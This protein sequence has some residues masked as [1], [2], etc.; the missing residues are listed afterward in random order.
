MFNDHILSIIMFTPA[1]GALVLLFM[2]KE[3]KNAI[4]WVAN[5]FAL[6]GL[7]VS[8]PLIP[9]FWAVKDQPKPFHF[10]EGAANTW[11]PSI[12]AG[13]MTRAMGTVS[14]WWDTWIIDGLLVNGP[15]IL[16]RLASYPVRLVQWGLVQWYALV[17]V[18]GVVG[19]A[20]YYVAR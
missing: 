12:G 20:I 8:I 5:I 6:G 16:A 2:P 3:N 1:V 4:R 7:A 9:M 14:K 13:W 11:I 17:M 15:A 19:F 10:V 18:G